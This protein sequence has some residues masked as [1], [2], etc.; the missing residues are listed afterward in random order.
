MVLEKLYSKTSY[1]A[2]LPDGSTSMAEWP[3]AFLDQGHQNITTKNV[4]RELRLPLSDDYNRLGF[5]Q[6]LTEKELFG[7]AV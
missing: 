5:C 7:Y 4:R 2:T 1:T 6:L 3:N